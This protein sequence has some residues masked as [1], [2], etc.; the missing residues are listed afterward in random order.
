VSET[1][2][3]YWCPGKGGI[4][5]WWRAKRGDGRA[6]VAH[7]FRVPLRLIGPDIGPAIEPYNGEL[8]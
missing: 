5:T 7:A 1:W 6:K 2:S 4:S 8:K 3:D